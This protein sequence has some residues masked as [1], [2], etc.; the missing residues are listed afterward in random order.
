MDA[1]S[2]LLVVVVSRQSSVVSRLLGWRRRPKRPATRRVR[3]YEIVPQVVRRGFGADVGSCPAV[4]ALVLQK[5]ESRG[6]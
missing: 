3:L 2:T 6:K 1:V 4:M 5:T